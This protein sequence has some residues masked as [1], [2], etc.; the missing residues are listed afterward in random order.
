MSIH[1]GC[2]TEWQCGKQQGKYLT[3]Q[4]LRNWSY[5]D[6]LG[7]GKW[8][9]LDLSLRLDISML[10]VEIIRYIG[11][12][13]PCHNTSPTMNS[14]SYIYSGNLICC[15]GHPAGHYWVP[16]YKIP[17]DVLRCVWSYFTKIVSAYRCSES[18]VHSAKKLSTPYL[19]W[20]LGN[21]K[22]CFSA[23]RRCHDRRSSLPGWTRMSMMVNSYTPHS[24]CM[25]SD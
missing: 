4:R 15:P 25:H 18:G 7:N 20:A 17:L 3:I 14:R 5:T 10:N 1:D 12:K 16:R 21:S 6:T 24:P 8:C 9:L 2:A 19:G 13:F 11:P 23:V 22:L